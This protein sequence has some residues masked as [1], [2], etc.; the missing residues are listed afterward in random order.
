MKR[1]LTDLQR[2]ALRRALDA[3]PEAVRSV[4]A[5]DRVTYASLFDRGLLTRH[6][7]RGRPA[8]SRD[9]AFEY[10]ATP[11]LVAAM[12]ARKATA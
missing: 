2:A 11:A 9:A 5:G 7:Y 1:T 4:T 12:A 6:D 3:Y 10:T 8:G